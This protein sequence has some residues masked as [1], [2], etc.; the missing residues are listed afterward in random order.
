MMSTDQITLYTNRGSPFSHFVEIALHESGLPFTRY[1][2]DLL[3]KPSWFATEINHLGK[4]PAFTYGGPSTTPEKPA[5]ESVKLAESV[6]LL[7]FINELAPEAKLLPSNPVERARVRFCLMFVV[8][9]LQPVVFLAMAQ[10]GSLAEVVQV[11]RDLQHFLPDGESSRNK[12][13]IGGDDFSLADAAAAA[14]VVRLNLFLG[15][16]LGSYPVGEGLKVH[17]ELQV[18]A[19]FSKYRAYLKAILGRK[20]VNETFPEVMASQPLGVHVHVLMQ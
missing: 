15:N 2:V 5:K 16:D 1:E 7:E 12:Q 17:K 9:K 13:F 18:S 10:R 8:T 3:S 14:I 19:E 11:V 6:A 20:S 4:V